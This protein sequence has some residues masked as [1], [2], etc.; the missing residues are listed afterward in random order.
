M[1]LTIL[2]LAASWAEP[3]RVLDAIDARIAAGAPT[4]LVLLPE[5]AIGGY[6]SPAGDFD[7][8]PYAESIDG[9]IATR[10]A[11]IARARGVYLVAPLVL[12]EGPAIYNAMACFDRAGAVAFIYRK[13]HPWLPELWAT[14]GAQP[15]PTLAIAGITLTIATC[16]DLH[17]LHADA[18]PQLAAADVLL[19]PSAWVEEPPDSRIPTLAGLAR[20]FGLHVANANWAAGVVRVPGQGASCFLGRDGAVIARAA[21]AG[22][23]DLEL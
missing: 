5:M 22:R 10:C 20:E 11:A 21:E 2:E 8:A 7:L 9:P 15:S 19:F 4:D 17:F 13:R 16:Y 14:P 1:R 3:A 23:I 6:C 18:A 12:R